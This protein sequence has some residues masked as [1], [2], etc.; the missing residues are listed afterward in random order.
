MD[1]RLKVAVVG[2]RDF[3]DEQRLKNVLDAINPTHIVSGGARGADTLARHYAID[4][5]IPCKEFIPKWE[6]FGNSAGP[7]RNKEIV[8][9]SDMIVAFWDGKSRGTKSTIDIAKQY[10]K[11]LAVYNY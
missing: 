4:N 8:R 10:R 7:I 3:K 5:R 6:L 1:D 9:A 2:G 11:R